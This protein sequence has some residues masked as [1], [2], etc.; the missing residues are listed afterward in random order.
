MTQR[1][2]DEDVGMNGLVAY[3]PIP[4]RI[5]SHTGHIY[6]NLDVDATAAAAAAMSTS[7]TTTTIDMDVTLAF[8]VPL[9][10]SSSAIDT[11]ANA[12]TWRRQ[13]I[14]RLGDSLVLRRR[15]DPTNVTMPNVMWYSIVA[16]NDELLFDID[17]LNG[18]L[19]MT[20]RS[21]QQ[22]SSSHYRL[23]VSAIELG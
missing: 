13:E 10:S 11:N 5:D 8:N 2:R 21:P 20:A 3:T 19:Y 15:R 7:T 23:V 16:G 4:L 12:K 18:S 14:A 22:S 17:C 6:T 9:S 1:A